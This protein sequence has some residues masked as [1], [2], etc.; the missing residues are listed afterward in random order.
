MDVYGKSGQGWPVWLGRGQWLNSGSLFRIIDMP[1]N[2]RL[3]DNIFTGKR[4]STGHP[5][6]EENIYFTI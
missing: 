1:Q 2:H 4:L 6:A 3:G 5:Q